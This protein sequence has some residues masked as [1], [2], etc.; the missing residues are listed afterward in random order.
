WVGTMRGARGMLDRGG[1]T[2]RLEGSS[3]TAATHLRS[4]LAIYDAEDM[5]SLDVPWWT[6]RAANRV[7]SF[8]ES[9]SGDGRV[10]E[11]GS[12]AST[13]WLGRRAAEVISIEHD[14]EFVEV[15]QRLTD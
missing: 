15:V 2:R 8:L 6:Y 14:T 3:S 13:T 9:R 4:M 10:F 11:W 5:A 1:I 12:G 7:E